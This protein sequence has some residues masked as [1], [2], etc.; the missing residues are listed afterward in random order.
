[1]PA[2]TAAKGKSAPR[3]EKRASASAAKPR[4]APVA[5]PKGG[6]KPRASA[7]R[8][9]AARMTLAEAM[10]ALEKA[11]SPLARKT[12]ARHGAPEPMFGVSF[13]EL[14]KLV[15]R[16]GVDHDLARQLWE[17]GNADARTLAVKVAD[18]ARVTDA[19][20]DHW[21]ATAGWRMA[22]TYVAQ[23]ASEAPSGRAT[24]ER[25]FGTGPGAVRNAAWELAGHLA[26]R[27]TGTPDAWFRDRIGEIERTVHAA[28]N[29]E[30]Y[31]MAHALIALGC[32]S[33]A[34][35]KAAEA[36]S[37]RIGTIEVDHGDT[38]CR[39]PQAIPYL[40]KT[41]AHSAAKGF[42]SPAAHER[43]REVPRTR[44]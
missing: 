21:V 42:E 22:T 41:W 33:A 6:A 30:R 28:P 14:G 1:M 32:R 3:T 8:A 35:R 36:A 26:M 2:K 20:L 38:S 4:K 31:A 37:K 16:I 10:S 9:P 7:A 44:C 27:D 5:A 18:P 23:L 43:T 13:A 25:W 19:E 29:W 39:T 34:F 40:E 17:T 15:K 12:Y 11:G 24:A